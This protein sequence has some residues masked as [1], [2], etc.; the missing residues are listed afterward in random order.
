MHTDT[1]EV[2]CLSIRNF[3]YAIVFVD[4]FTG[5]VWV[6]LMKRK[7]ECFA[8]FQEFEQ[9]VATRHGYKIKRL[10]FDGGSE[11][12][13]KRF[14]RYLDEHQIRYRTSPPYTPE[15]NGTAERQMR[16]LMEATR[17]QLLQASLP[18]E[19][20]CLALSNAAYIRNIIVQGEREHTPS[21]L[22]TGEKPD[23]S[24][25]RIWGSPAFVHI[26]KRF[27][28]KSTMP[29]REC[30]L[31]GYDDD[32]SCWM[33]WDIQ[34]EKLIKSWHARIFENAVNCKDQFFSSPVV[35]L[36]TPA[37]PRRWMSYLRARI[38]DVMNE[39]PSNRR[40]Q[41]TQRNI[42]PALDAAASPDLPGLPGLPG[43]SDPQGRPYEDDIESIA[44]DD[45]HV[46]DVSEVSS[47]DLT[48]VSSDDSDSESNSATSVTNEHGLLNNMCN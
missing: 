42:G 5:F 12:N 4:E 36:F 3:K 47:T 10:K 44:S 8:K 48:D 32:S 14:L 38:H 40:G 45:T 19:Y 11:Y 7:T 22:L 41:H 2:D 46:S 23:I 25:L 29:G 31:V 37:R 30:L 17:S 43:R 27:R 9:K 20:W 15:I 24:R 6:G 21:E 18:A 26:E 33:F 35:P 28:T 13:N 34:R 1:L 16:T 39:A